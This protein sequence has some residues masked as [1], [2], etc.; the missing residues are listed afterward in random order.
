[1]NQNVSFPSLSTLLSGDKLQR[2]TLGK[3]F[4]VWESRS[5]LRT[6]NGGWRRTLMNLF[7]KKLHCPRQL[8]CQP[9]MLMSAPTAAVL[10]TTLQK[11]IKG[12]VRA[13]T[14]EVD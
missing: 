4:K 1:M 14:T 11:D 6:G 2:Q 3:A 5:T 13:V 10:G 8:R 12:E 7:A 9:T